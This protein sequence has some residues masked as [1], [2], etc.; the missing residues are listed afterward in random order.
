MNAPASN[1]SGRAAARLTFARRALEL[2][3]LELES[4]SSD[5]SFRSY[6]RTLGATPSR[7]VMDAPPERENLGPWI[8]VARQLGAADICAP[9]ILAEDLDQGFL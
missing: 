9:Q 3:T 2:P 5:A 7:I 6:W 4:A 1:T 8:E